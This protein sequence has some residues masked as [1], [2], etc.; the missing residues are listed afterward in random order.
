[1]DKLKNSELAKF[2]KEI[3][4]HDNKKDITFLKYI[5]LVGQLGLVMVIN[6]VLWFALI[7]WLISITGLSLNLQFIGILIGVFAGGFSCYKLMEKH[8]RIK[9]DDE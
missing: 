2:K 1:M 8:L 6:I 9:K 5:A 3:I 4:L 7:R